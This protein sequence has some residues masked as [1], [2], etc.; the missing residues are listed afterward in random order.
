M[1]IS[2]TVSFIQTKKIVSLWNCATKTIG[3]IFYFK[4]TWWDYEKQNKGS[5]NLF[6]LCKVKL[7]YYTYRLNPNNIVKLDDIESL[8]KSNNMKVS[9][10]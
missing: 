7:I 2:D 8:K 10:V 4:E 9:K 6:D 5:I 1:I 3:Q